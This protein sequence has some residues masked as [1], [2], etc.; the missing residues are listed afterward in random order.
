MGTL[1]GF[2]SRCEAPKGVELKGL[3]AWKGW[4][5][6]NKVLGRVKCQGA[7]KTTCVVHSPRE[8]SFW[9]RTL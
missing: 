8:E 6:R 9:E 3:N 2:T 5:P 7:R 1:V 4:L